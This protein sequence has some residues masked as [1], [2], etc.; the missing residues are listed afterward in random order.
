MPNITALAHDLRAV[1]MRVSRRVRLNTHNLPPHQFT[2]LAQLE[3]SPKTA[4]ELAE[5]E[6]VSAPSMSRTIRELSDRGLLT[7]EVSEVDRRCHV[8][9]LTDAGLAELHEGRRTR[10]QWMVE[11]LRDCTPEEQKILTEA[12]TILQRLLDEGARR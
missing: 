11:R 6:Q 5:R 10:D 2:V 1:C 4:S 3:Q 7:S 9:S 8:L 12:T